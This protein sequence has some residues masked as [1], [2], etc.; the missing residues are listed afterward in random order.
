MFCFSGWLLIIQN[1]KIQFLL[2]FMYL[3]FSRQYYRIN[4]NAVHQ[5][6]SYIFVILQT[7]KV[8]AG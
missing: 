6:G 2:V 5:W 1:V 3:P 8:P 7:D 4:L